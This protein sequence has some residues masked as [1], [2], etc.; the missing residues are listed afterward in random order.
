MNLIIAG[1]YF[2]KQI[3]IS[4][5][6]NIKQL[7]VEDIEKKKK[8]L[9]NFDDCKNSNMLKKNFKQDRYVI[10]RLPRVIIN[11]DET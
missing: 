9:L 11:E 2:L 10:N 5:N 7:C 6:I 1:D 3:S 8:L 4:Q